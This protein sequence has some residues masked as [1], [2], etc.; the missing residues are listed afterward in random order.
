ME[1]KTFLCDNCN[2][3]HPLPKETLFQGQHLCTHCLDLTTMV[4]SRCNK[5]IWRQDNSS[6]A[7]TPLC[8]HCYTHFYTI[9]DRCGR[10]LR[11]E[12]AYY[13]DEDSDNSLCYD[14]YHSTNRS[15]AIRDYYFKPVPVFL[16]EGPRY[17][18]VELEVDGAGEDDDNAREVMDIANQETV[19]LY[20]KH[21]GSLDDGFVCT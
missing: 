2:Q 20:C 7:E 5:R 19:T 11:N 9:C 12:D 10:L 17:F 3:Y 1:E 8:D 21:D 16:G 15:C 14:C 4:C 13:E 6:S 18:G